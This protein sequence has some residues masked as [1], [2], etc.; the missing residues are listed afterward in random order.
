MYVEN[1][2]HTLAATWTNTMANHWQYIQLTGGKALV[3]YRAAI[4][5]LQLSAY[6]VLDW[7]VSLHGKFLLWRVSNTLQEAHDLDQRRVGCRRSPRKASQ[8]LQLSAANADV[9]R[10]DGWSK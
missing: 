1:S 2:T 10:V 5:G 3:S 9:R 8:Y 6:H 4:Q 7:A